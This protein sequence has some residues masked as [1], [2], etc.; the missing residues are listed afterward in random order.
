M[1]PT[2][3]VSQ[4]AR[5]EVKVVLSGDGG[6]EPFLG[7]EWTRR[8]MTLPRLLPTLPFPGWQWAY[9]DGLAGKTQ[10]LLYDISHNAD[11]RYLRR[12]T[13]PAAFCHWLLEPE[14]FPDK[15]VEPLAGMITTLNSHV[16]ANRFDVS[17]LM[18]YLPEDVLFKVDRM[19][20]AYGLEV[21]VP[22][23]DHHLLE[24]ALSLPDEIRFRHGHGK[25]LLRKVAERYLPSKLLEPRKQG[26]TIPV[27]QWLRGE[28][29]ERVNEIF[30]SE[31]FASR[32]V[33]RP[34]RALKLL[35]MHRSGSFDLG[36]RIWSIVILE[37]WFRVWMDD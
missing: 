1:L 35:E 2:F 32:G 11:A 4:Q 28:M 26:F 27:A 13:A 33:V 18:N 9:R 7:Y 19:S 34:D 21:R 8:A 12:I 15:R 25:W 3:L 20:M 17:D 14:M 24:F 23:L 36:H 30:S 31:S 16:G 37:M 22:L 29:E 5:K 10:R 6:D